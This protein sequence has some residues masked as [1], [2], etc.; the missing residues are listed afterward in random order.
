MARLWEL[1]IKMPPKYYPAIGE[2]VY[3]Q[4]LLEFQMQVIIW[5]ALELDNKKGRTLTV[6]MGAK[7]LIGIIKTITLRWAALSD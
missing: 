5:R 4:A 6:G 2:V 7:P 1:P 3:R